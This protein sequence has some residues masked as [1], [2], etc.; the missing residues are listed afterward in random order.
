MADNIFRTT[1][2]GP[3]PQGGQQG[4]DP[5]AELA[6]L[7]GRTNPQA[8][9][10]RQDEA[11]PRDAPEA[12][13]EWPA[14][15]RYAEPQQTPY[16]EPQRYA[17]P[18]ARYDQDQAQDQPSDQYGA[19][20][21]AQSSGQH[22]NQ[23]DD[24][25]YDDRRDAPP[26]P[27]P[28][29]TYPPYRS[30][31]PSYNAE[32]ERPDPYAA[33]PQRY[34]AQGHDAQGHDAQ[35]Y[36]DQSGYQ[37]DP[38]YDDA[39]DPI[40][41]L[42]AFLPRGHDARRDNRRDDRYDD[43]AEEG[44]S[45][46]DQF[47]ELEDY[48]EDD[49]PP[50]K[51]RGFAIF[52]ALLGLMVLGTAGAFSYRAMFGGSM[53]PALPPIIKADGTPNKIVPA[54]KAANAS[55]QAANNSGSPDRLVSREE[56]PVDVPAP[57]TTPRVVS[58]IPVFPDPNAGLQASMTGEA[59]SAPNMLGS[60]A[61]APGGAAGVPM[62]LGPAGVA[63]VYPPVQAAPDQSGQAQVA[64][65]VAGT[66]G[67]KKIRTVAIHAGQPDSADAAATAARP[68]APRPVGAP[69]GG[70]AGQGGNGPLSIVPSQGGQG[71]QAGQGSA[72]TSRTRTALA[73]PAAAAAAEPALAAAGGGYSVQVSSQRSEAEAQAAYHGLQAK[74]PAQLGSRTAT[75]R[76]VDLG[77]KG[78]YY[79]TLVGPYGS[80]EEAAQMC[81][82]LKAAGGSCL[83]Q[84][85]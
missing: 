85:N 30:A 7:I 51:R 60:I 82:S 11:P 84:R 50:R 26:Q 36:N 57:A 33:Q 72:D 41:D 23:Y 2:R 24:R 46:D 45:E 20:Y 80:A 69:Q 35:A 17:E 65:P 66:S 44:Q 28:A 14:D 59:Q 81:S 48:E 31:P 56:R 47:Y 63:P 55:G 39:H 34:D 9:A 29:D 32:Y 25:Q 61:P 76:Q 68:V 21:P 5:L 40:Q 3:A 73:H 79:R 22:D 74:Y 27:Q 42:P 18:Q 38:R 43:Y 83:V 6:R 71:S 1:R 77:D 53:L 12:T 75:V 64:A 4:D 52:A 16:A 8:R 13:P 15:A 67:S 19:Q 54:G 58:T 10:A 49:A 37:D 78:I 62:Q 70:Q